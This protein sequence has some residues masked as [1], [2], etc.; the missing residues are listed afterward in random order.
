[1]KRKGIALCLMMVTVMMTS[2]FVFGAEKLTIT[3]TYPV[4]GAKN[5]TKDNM[6]VKVYFNN[7]V[8]NKTSEAA[9][10][11][12]FKITDPKGKSFPCNIYYNERNPKYALI[13]ID[14]NKVKSTGK[15]KYVIQDNTEYTC[16]IS[17]DFQDNN[18][19][20]LGED[21]QIKFTTLNYGR[22][23]M[24]YMVLMFVMFGGMMFF[25]MRQ[26]RKS[27][28]DDKDQKDAPFNPYTEAK[29]TGKSLE[30]VIAK[31][32]KDVEKKEAARKAKAK[33]D[34]EL[35]DLLEEEDSGNY[36]VSKPLRIADA[37]A[38][39]RTGRKALAEEKKREEEARK[40]ER[41]A[42]GYTKKQKDQPQTTQKKG[43]KKK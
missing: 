1:M 24:M 32:E 31:H 36:R 33:R 19:T 17:K 6:C 21:V 40:A 20:K 35:D 43:K 22:N 28:E 39:Y 14:T 3:S 42:A 7:D 10:E 41:K 11:N 16:T 25:S 2:A 30:E 34:K 9:N 4:D 38:K 27:K 37:G 23:T 12:A 15:G 29:R 8:G 5:T 13:L 26:Q 18:G